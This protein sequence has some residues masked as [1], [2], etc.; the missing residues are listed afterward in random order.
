MTQRVSSDEKN[1]QL[2]SKGSHRYSAGTCEKLK[3]DR[4]ENKKVI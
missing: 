3:R 1:K 4:L 2:W